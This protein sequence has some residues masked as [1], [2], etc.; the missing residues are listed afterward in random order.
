MKPMTF[1]IIFCLFLGGCVSLQDEGAYVSAPGAP[2]GKV[3]NPMANI[4][5][6]MSRQEVAALTKNE[7]MIGYN[8]ESGPHKSE[9]ILLAQPY[10]AEMLTRG[11]KT[12]HILYY[13]TSVNRPDDLVADDE[14]TP[15]IFENDALVGKGLADLDRI[16]RL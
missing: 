12:Y 5:T 15:L 14:L 7:L 16:K 6:G 4:K 2:A 13:F 8:F 1:L 11:G 10:R 9:P 3:F